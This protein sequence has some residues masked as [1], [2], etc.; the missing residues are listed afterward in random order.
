MGLRSTVALFVCVAV[1]VDS[2]ILFSDDSTV[3]F[4]GQDYS[5][6][7][8]WV[9]SLTTD[10]EQQWGRIRYKM[11]SADATGD[12]Y[13]HVTFM[14]IN[15]G[16]GTYSTGQTVTQSLRV[17]DSVG[18]T[19]LMQ[20]TPDDSVQYLLNIDTGGPDGELNV[21][22]PYE[23]SWTGEWTC[24]E[25]FT[26]SAAQ[27]IRL[28]EDGALVYE[29]DDDLTFVGPSTGA[30]IDYTLGESLDLRIGM[31]TYNGVAVSGSFKD[32]A[33]KTTRLGCG[34]ED[35]DASD[36]GIGND[37]DDED[38]D[39]NDDGDD[40]DDDDDD[41]GDDDD[42]DDDYDDND[43]D[44]RPAAGNGD[45]SDDAS[46]ITAAVAIAGLMAVVA[47]VYCCFCRARSPSSGALSR[48]AAAKG[49]AT[50]TS[51]ALSFG[52]MYP[53]RAEPTVGG[54][55]PS[56]LE[57]PGGVT[58]WEAVRDEASGDTYWWNKLT[59]ETSWD[60]PAGAPSSV[61]QLV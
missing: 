11:D 51:A 4:S 26:D 5:S 44:S 22:T 7:T 41:G 8:G 50:R 2:E 23:Y 16:I 55:P 20:S 61:A 15:N 17:V 57:Q 13:A 9:Y 45:K 52:K 10:A 12:R 27:Q 32:V 28:Y 25:W 53:T 3:N 31:F 37:D 19:R 60:R 30:T 21:D 40:G 29:I 33:V 58:P 1:A 34:T 24:M 59:D 14:Q 36:E 56:S 39:D 6:S 18:S 47:V 35:D 42:N 54:T 46:A 43:D 38:D 48:Q 49:G